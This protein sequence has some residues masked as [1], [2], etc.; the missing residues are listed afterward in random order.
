MAEYVKFLRGTQANYNAMS[1]SARSADNV[2]ITTD[3]GSIYLGNK[4]LG[5]YIEV[6]NIN[7]MLAKPVSEIADGALYY[8]IAENVLARYDRQNNKWVQLNAAGLSAISVDNTGNVLSGVSVVEDPTTKQKTL[9]FTTTSVATST[10]LQTLQKTVSDMDAA[11]KQADIALDGKITEAKTAASNAQKAA[12]A[13]TEAIGALDEELQGQIDS[14][15]EAIGSNGL[16]KEVA[17]LKTADQNITKS[18]SDMDAAY[19]AAD[20]ALRKELTGNNSDDG[21]ATGTYKTINA[22]SAALDALEDAH[23]TLNGTVTGE[24]GHAS[25][26]AE[27]ESAIIAL[28]TAIGENGSVDEAIDA[29]VAALRREIVT[30]GTLN[31]NLLQAYDTITEIATWLQGAENADNAGALI[32]DVNSLIGTVG[33]ASSGLVKDVADLKSAD[34]TIRNEFANADTALEKKLAAGTGGNSEFATGAYKNIN[35]LSEQLEAAEGNISSLSSDLSTLSGTVGGHT[36]DIANLNTNLTNTAAAIREEFA[37]ADNALKAAIVSGEA[38][39]GDY[40]NINTLSSHMKT[41]EGNI[42]TISGDLSTLSGT[43]GSH[44]T[45]IANIWGQLTWGAF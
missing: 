44:T 7:T 33:D 30:D 6:A 25:R 26:I 40:K 9:T 27:A 42:S 22:L 41:A 14:I 17:D 3:T 18:I 19:K 45:E 21:K 38:G 20:L 4:R 35:K 37:N 10:D 15:N 11:Y 23:D 16:A 13:N 32:S 43:V 2:Y 29:A 1:A 8:A 24:G 12:D 5:D 28:Q 36:T 39:S 34:T 31:D